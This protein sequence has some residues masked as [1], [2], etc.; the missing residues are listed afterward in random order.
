MAFYKI[1]DTS[2]VSALIVERDKRL[3][4]FKQIKDFA[5]KYNFL[6]SAYV[7]N[8]EL[9]MWFSGFIAEKSNSDQIDKSKW[10]FFERKDGYLQVN[11][12]KSNKK[13][14]NEIKGEY[15]YLQNYP[16][17]YEKQLKLLDDNTWNI[18]DIVYDNDTI[19]FETDNLIQNPHDYLI[20]VLN[21]EY[22]STR[23][24]LELD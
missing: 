22:L 10:K 9:G 19:Y 24:K 5:D 2:I 3:L 23:K 14:Y 8:R 4:F 20:E 13:F 18:A 15:E 21:S 7:D 6:S 1:Q 17:R 16:F 12:K 11:P